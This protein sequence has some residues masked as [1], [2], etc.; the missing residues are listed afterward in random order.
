MNGRG[1]VP[2]SPLAPSHG[3]VAARWQRAA[4][5]A[6][7]AAAAAADDVCL[8]PDQLILQQQQQPPQQRQ[9]QQEEEEAQGKPPAR[10]GAM[11]RGSVSPRSIA[12]GSMARSSR[13]GSSVGPIA[14]VDGTP[15]VG[16]DEVRCGCAKSNRASGTNSTP[17]GDLACGLG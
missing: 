8:D 7:A 17:G 5:A 4:T 3:G 14:A 2:T 6:R 16:V 15:M 10:L 13:A 11:A 1:D 12:R 9:Q